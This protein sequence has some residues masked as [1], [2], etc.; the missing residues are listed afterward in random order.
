VALPEGEEPPPLRRPDNIAPL[1]VYLASDESA[2]ITGQVF[3]M[4]GNILSLFSHPRPIHPTE[5]AGAWTLDALRERLPREFRDRL[6]PVG[7]AAAEYQFLPR[8]SG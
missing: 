4:T 2:W 5:A 1:V 8:A 7:L 6:E 3:R